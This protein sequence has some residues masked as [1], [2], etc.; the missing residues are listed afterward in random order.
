MLCGNIV[1]CTLNYISVICLIRKLDVKN[2]YEKTL[3]LY[4]WVLM[5]GLG[6]KGPSGWFGLA[7][8]MRRGLIFSGSIKVTGVDAYIKV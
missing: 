7:E 3:V 5:T 8:K 6:F 4:D 1:L 2:E